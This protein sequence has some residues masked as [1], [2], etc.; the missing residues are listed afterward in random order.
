MYE[1]S[2]FSGYHC[3]DSQFNKILS[4]AQRFILSHKLTNKSSTTM[5]FQAANFVLEPSSSSTPTV[6]SVVRDMSN[7]V[8]V[9]KTVGKNKKYSINLNKNNFL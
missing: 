9:I 4:F 7:K 3:Y 8:Y 6:W 2:F 1:T 5:A